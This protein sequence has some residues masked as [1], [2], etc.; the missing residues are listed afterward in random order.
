MEEAIVEASVGNVL[1]DV[2][3][4]G[5]IKALKVDH[6]NGSGGGGVELLEVWTVRNG[7]DEV[8]GY[9]IHGGC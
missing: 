1:D 4:I 2:G 8:G 5:A 6:G 9:T 3:A 7:S